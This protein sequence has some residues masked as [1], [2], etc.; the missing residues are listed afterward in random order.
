[1]IISLVCVTPWQFIGNNVSEVCDEDLML[2][3]QGGSLAAFEQL[4]ARHKGPLFRYLLRGCSDRHQ[5]EELFQE[6]WTGLIKARARYQVQASFKTYLYQLAH[7]RLVDHYR[8]R[9]LQLVDDE[10][11]QQEADPR[12]D[13]HQAANDAD[14]VER[15]K[16]QL[17]RLPAEQREAFVLQQETDLS[18]EQIGQLGGVG[19]ETVKSRLRYALKQL[20]TALE[21]CL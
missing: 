21:D 14:C 4:Y 8:R 1:M 16:Q 15:L 5:A 3:Y 20:R 7:N 13:L 10:S 9:S 11:L 17:D 12:P 6:V 18:L 19:R 2:S